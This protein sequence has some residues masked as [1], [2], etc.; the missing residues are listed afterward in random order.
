MSSAFWPYE[1]VQFKAVDAAK[2]KFSLHTPWIASTFEVAPGST[3]SQALLQWIEHKENTPPQYLPGLWKVLSVL[4]ELPIAYELPRHDK[5]FGIDTHKNK[6][7]FTAKT[8]KDFAKELGLPFSNSFTSEWSWDSDSILE[9]SECS[10]GLYDPLSVLSVA[11]RFHYLDDDENKMK[12]IYNFVLKIKSEKE[13]KLATAH[14]VRQNHFVTEKCL[15]SVSPALETAQSQRPLVEQFIKEEKGHDAILGVGLKAMN[16]KTQDLVITHAVQNLMFLLEKSGFHNFLAFC[17][18]LDFFEKPQFKDQ[19]SLAQV[20]HKL[21]ESTASRAL[22]A[23]KNINDHGEHEGFSRKLLL[24]MKPVEKSYLI[25][26]LQ[27][28]ELVSKSI[29][30]VSHEL[31]KLIVTN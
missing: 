19:D 27:M 24:N 28:T 30:H 3:E 13:R 26:A 7:T 4:Q 6:K 12:E 8:P 10:A 15:S 25:Q 23:H 9:F 1:E 17:I 2:G 16:I 11:R 18:C 29:I 14:I 22:Q 31:Q 20:L 5:I 21:G